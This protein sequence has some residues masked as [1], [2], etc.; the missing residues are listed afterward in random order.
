[1]LRSHG[2]PARVR[3][4]Y[5]NYLV[6]GFSVDHTIVE[7]WDEGDRRWRRFD[8][9][10]MVPTGALQEPLDQPV[11]EGAP[12]RTAAEVWQGWRAGALD[13]NAYGVRPAG[14]RPPRTCGNGRGVRGWVVEDPTSGG[15]SVFSQPDHRFRAYR[16]SSPSRCDCIWRFL[17]VVGI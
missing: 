2:I 4:G 5:A 3:Y 1:M 15:F 10:V 9:E 14:V 12:F 8:P 13:P 6:R 16:L 11:G 17:D 7:V